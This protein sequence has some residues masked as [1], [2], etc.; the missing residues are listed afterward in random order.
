MILFIII[1][2][3]LT[4][5]A[6]LIIL[7]YPS[8]IFRFLQKHYDKA[9]LQIFS[10]V[11]RFILGLFLILES[12]SSKFPTLIEIFGWF[13][14]IAALIFAII[15]RSRYNSII[16][17]TLPHSGPG[18]RQCLWASR[19]D[20]CDTIWCFSNLCFYVTEK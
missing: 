13:S 15:G 12:N 5:L 8:I 14:I 4:L 9:I 16:A 1:Y 7:I 2:S 11:I 6:G 17:G 3:I 10:V 19:R 18:I 20:I